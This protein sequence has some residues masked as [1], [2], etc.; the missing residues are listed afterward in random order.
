METVTIN[1]PTG[2]TRTMAFDMI[3]DAFKYDTESLVENISIIAGDIAI[4]EGATVLRNIYKQVEVP[5]GYKNVDGD[6]VKTLVTLDTLDGTGAAS[7]V[8][9]LA[10]DSLPLT[11]VS[12]VEVFEQV[13]APDV[14]AG[15]HL[16]DGALIESREISVGTKLNKEDF[17]KQVF[18]S[19]LSK[20]FSNVAQTVTGQLVEKAIKTHREEIEA[21]TSID[22]STGSIS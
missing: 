13:L 15:T 6:L 1:L 20:W 17:G 3:A 11:Y 22:T 14:D 8:E 12:A 9:V 18:A 10:G 19:E 2:I 7:V 5:N 16:V 21:S 4:P